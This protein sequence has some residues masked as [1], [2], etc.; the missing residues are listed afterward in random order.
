VSVKSRIKETIMIQ[1]KSIT[2]Q[3]VSH[4]LNVTIP[5]E[6]LDK[7]F[8]EYW[9]SVKDS[10]H[11]NLIKAA[12]KGGF[13]KII[14]ERVIHAAGGRSSFYEP[15]LMRQVEEFLETQERQALV[16]DTVS[17][18]STESEYG[19]SSVVYLEP[20]VK[21]ASKPGIDGPLN[22]VTPAEPANLLEDLIQAELVKKQAELANITP[23]DSSWA[24]PGQVVEVSC[25]SYI[26]NRIGTPEETL[27]VWE[28]G[29][30]VNAK[31]EVNPTSILQ[32]ELYQALVGASIPSTVCVDMVLNEK[33]GQNAGNNIRAIVNVQQLFDKSTPEINDEMAKA[34]G[35]DSLELYKQ[36][37]SINLTKKIIDTRAQYKENGIINALS[38]VAT[39]DQI[40]A[41]WAIRKGEALYQ[42]GLQHAKTEQ[43]LLAQFV[44][45]KCVSGT[46]VTNKNSLITFLSEQATQ[47]LVLDLVLR[48]WGKLGSVEGDTTLRSM[49][50]YVKSVKA[51]LNELA[52]ETKGEVNGLI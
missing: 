22:I 9:D 15:V 5:K 19:I 35:H 12:K 11:P 13:R 48:S 30:V 21:W 45:A 41:Q 42:E 3:A 34:A 32:P 23:T 46:P 36:A 44:N 20:E 49:P 8:D 31:W 14:R 26:V 38:K 28:P 4:V 43:N 6:E 2:Q 39:I 24:C 27:T 33:F 50:Q 10:L 7:K 17:V 25:K 29:T 51:K 40:P 47:N 16:I 18:T 37:L 52:V 1:L